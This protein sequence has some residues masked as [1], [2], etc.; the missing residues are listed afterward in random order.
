M[1][2][3]FIGPKQT[4]IEN[5]NFFNYSITLFGTNQ[6]NNISYSKE[7][8]FEYWNPDNINIEIEYYNK[9]LAKIRENVEL[10]AH[11][12]LTLSYCN[13]PKNVHLICKNP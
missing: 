3:I 2:R 4:T 6:G 8:N 10:M 5:N 11:N 13:I 9:Q 1:K 12:P 7:L